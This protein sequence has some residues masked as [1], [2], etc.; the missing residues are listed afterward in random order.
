MS[1]GHICAVAPSSGHHCLEVL[2]NSTAI[3]AGD[4]ET[5]LRWK[6]DGD[7]GQNKHHKI[8]QYSNERCCRPLSKSLFRDNLSL[9]DQNNTVHPGRV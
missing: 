8:P 9:N 2:G 5:S 7:T 1:W 3:L 6:T 4:R